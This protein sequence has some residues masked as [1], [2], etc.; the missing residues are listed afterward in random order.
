VICNDD[1][2]AAQVAVPGTITVARRTGAVLNAI[3]RWTHEGELEALRAT[4]D[5]RVQVFPMGLEEIFLELF[6]DL[7]TEPN[8]IESRDS[9]KGWE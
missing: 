8:P 1:E 7:P 9:K 5:I 4:A 3:V 2:L 6:G